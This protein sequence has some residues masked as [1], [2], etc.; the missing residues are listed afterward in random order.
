MDDYRLTARDRQKLLTR[1]RVVDAARALFAE[2]G[3][4]Q[5]TIRD[6][7]ARAGVAP[8]SVFTTFATKADLLLEIVFT[9]YLTL[10]ESLSGSLAQEPDPIERLVAIARIA[11]SY[12]LS[13]PRLLAETIGAS[14]TWSIATDEE[15]RQ[16]L[17]P[18][19][20]LVEKALR[21]GVANGSVSKS[22]DIAL[23]SE[24]IFAMYLRNY[25]LA[26]FDAHDA[27]ALTERFRRQVHLILSE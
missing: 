16:R 24:M 25:R 4:E 27:H 17:A 6:I 9:R 26:L 15:H 2:K 20:G 18:L 5:A 10:A 3:Y 7:A 13:E 12:E 19:V 23:A 8:G 11:Y 1:A 22:L 21:D 14:W